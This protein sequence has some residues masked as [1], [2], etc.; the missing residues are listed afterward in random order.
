MVGK[1]VQPLIFVTYKKEISLETTNTTTLAFSRSGDFLAV[2]SGKRATIWSA[3]T[4]QDIHIINGNSTVLSL[5]WEMDGALYCG[6]KDGMCVAVHMDGH[7][8]VCPGRYYLITKSYQLQQ[9]RSHGFE[10]LD[11]PIHHLKIHE[12]GLLMALGGIHKVSIF[13]RKDHAGN[14]YGHRASFI[15][16]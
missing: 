10:A 13:E 8:E 9:L 4:G 2:A 14:H 1:F 15:Q 6:F 12:D 7:K 3:T 16:N 5:F 11:Q